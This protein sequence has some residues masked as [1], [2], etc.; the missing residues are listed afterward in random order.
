M[1]KNDNRVEMLK[2]FIYGTNA[3]LIGGLVSLPFE[4][5]RGNTILLP[6]VSL[7]AVGIG[8]LLLGLLINGGKREGVGKFF[9][10]SIT[11]Y[12]AV[13]LVNVISISI[14][15]GQEFSLALIISRILIPAIVYSIVFGIQ[16]YGFSS[17]IVFL[18]ASI[19]SA[20]PISLAALFFYLSN[21][22]LLGF[23]SLWM[24]ASMGAAI[25]VSIK[26]F[27]MRKC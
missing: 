27:V 19:L 14:S 23:E 25:A 9:I 13:I 2:A 6:R 17:V 12:L 7:I 15:L 18:T 11:S 22:K 24:Y 20:L 4:W 1:M 16:L 10:I 3:Y 5:I 8:G 21:T 26:S